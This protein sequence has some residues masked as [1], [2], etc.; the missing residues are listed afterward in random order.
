MIENWNPFI[1]PGDRIERQEGDLR[2]VDCSPSGLRLVVFAQEHS[3]VIDV[4]HPERVQLRP[5]GAGPLEFTCG[6]QD[7]RRGAG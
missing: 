5:A 3:L 4:T 2:E 1:E 6:K 7:G